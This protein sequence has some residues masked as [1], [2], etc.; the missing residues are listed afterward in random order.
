VQQ[1][2]LL[3]HALQQL[4]LLLRVSL[5]SRGVAGL[6]TGGVV[7]LLLLSKTTPAALPAWHLHTYLI[8]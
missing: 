6:V 4:L 5:G 8:K 2:Q 1:Q 3:L 7:L